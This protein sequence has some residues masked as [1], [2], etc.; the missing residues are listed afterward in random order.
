MTTTNRKAFENLTKKLAVSEEINFE[1]AESEVSSVALDKTTETLTIILKHK[2]LIPARILGD[3]QAL[4]LDE[5]KEYRAVEIVNHFPENLKEATLNEFW[6]LIIANLKESSGSFNLLDTAKWS[7]DANQLKLELASEAIKVH[8]IDK[9]V[10]Q[11]L[12]KS[13]FLWFENP[14][15]VIL[16]VI[17]EQEL[18]SYG[19]LLKAELALDIKEMLAADTTATKPIKTEKKEP[20]KL[21]YGKKITGDSQA[22]NLLHTEED[23]VLVTGKVF[24]LEHKELK[25]N[26]SIITIGLTDN[27]DSIEAKLY[28]R[29]AA[30]NK[31]L[32]EQIAEDDWLSVKGNLRI[33]KYTSQLVL[34]VSAIQ[35]YETDI[36]TDTAKT[37]RVELHLHTN[38][39]T[40]DGVSSVK[41]YIERAK[42]L[43]H[44]AIAV[45]DHGVVQAYPDAYRYGQEYGIKVIYG[46]EANVL[47][48]NSLIVTN[49]KEQ[50][51]ADETFVIF[52]IETTGLS[53]NSNK[54][55]EIGAVKINGEN[56][57]DRYSTFVNPEEEI[58][59]F[60]SDLT[61]IQN[62]DLVDAPGIKSVLAEFNNFIGDST[63]VA[64]NSRFDIAFIN[65]ALGKNG[66]RPLNN[67]IIDALALAR[68]LYPNLKN[69][70]LETLC[71]HHNIENPD[72]HR[73]LS[74]AEATANLFI[75]QLKQLAEKAIYTLKDLDLSIEQFDFKKIWPYHVSILVKNKIGLKNLYQ[76]VSDSH[77]QFFF[78]QPR[79][80]KDEISKCR[81]GL[82]IGSGC[83]KGELVDA[84]L[85]K[86]EA[87]IEQIAAYYDYLEVQPP[88]CY[89]HLLSNNLVKDQAEVIELIKKIIELGEKLSIPVVATGNVH[90]LEPEE[91]LNR[92]ILIHNQLSGARYH[93]ANELYQAHY[94]STTDML[95]EFSFVDEATAEKIVINNTRLINDQIDDLEPFPSKLYTPVIA[96]A[97]QEITELSYTNAKKIYGEELP[98]LVEARLT[99]E[100]ASIIDNGFAVIYLISHKLVAQSLADGYLVGSRGSVGSS[101]VATMT[102]IT[103]VNPLP[104]HYVCQD[105]NYSHFITDGT[106]ESGYD[107]PDK[108]CPKC[109]K[110]MKKDG[111]DIPFETFMG[112]KGDKVPDI[113]L[114]F[115]GEYQA[116]IH[117]QTEEIFGEKKVFRA[118]TIST[119]A[120]KTAFGYVR[121]YMKDNN[122]NLREAEV[123]RLAKGC[124][125][126]KRTTG[127]HPGGQIVIPQNTDVTEFTPIQRPAD[128][129]N[130]EVITTHFDYHALSGT[131]LK[132]D[133]LGHDDPTAL[134]MLQDLT[135]VDPRSIAFDDPKLYQLFTST[136]PL[137][138]E[139][140]RGEFANGAIGIPE[141]G[142]KFVRQMLDETCP[143]TFIELVRI[144]GLSHGIDVWRNNAQDLIKRGE[145]N[146]T[147]VIC[148]RDDIMLYL[149]MQGLDSSEAF[150]ISERVR[151][152][153]GLTQENINEMRKHTVPAWYIESCQKIKYMFPKAHAVAYVQMAIRIAY[154]KIYYPIEYYATYL[155]LRGGD[156]DITEVLGNHNLKDR[157]RELNRLGNDAS[158]KEKDLLNA[159]E[160]I[161][162]MNSRGI[163]FAPVELYEST[164]KQ[165]VIAPDRKS[166]IPPFSSIPGVGENL[167]NNIVEA[168]KQ[169]EFI[170]IEDLQTRCR[171]SNTI[172]EEFNRLGVL[173]GLNQTDQISLF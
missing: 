62:E 129:V 76:L 146:L 147:Q 84:L 126:V 85:N 22:I 64:Y 155:T 68:Y 3:F 152:G 78:R 167:A 15:K 159:L 54:I 119:I 9:D 75:L 1:Y 11:Y 113:D 138:I 24:S 130:S 73:A 104:P 32:V 34:M 19:K 143:T 139:G 12:N 79:I 55:I 52:D 170:S 161:V 154:Y 97:D 171:I 80:I 60:I 128:D 81:E 165:Y 122:L 108:I 166:I 169:G 135:G 27:Q 151:K 31:Q 7:I 83:A 25:N 58:S 157:V 36:V 87:E 101:F 29:N 50:T 20:K 173:K 48:S 86:T 5:L 134:K 107:L 92:R 59:Q 10:I 67:A 71:K 2:Q 61:N 46:L 118:G 39:S 44:E 93:H 18:K 17:D 37:K 23:N 38:M 111:H 51:L 82:L 41:R 145:A 153:R 114:N 45:T 8:L 96:G 42:E 88:G 142:T 164:A 28:N 141:F 105:C 99:K 116:R 63:L 70:R 13:L 95:K 43:G 110:L 33:D 172:I 40:M 47:V 69:H 133:L 117:R 149:I 125:G 168:R 91:A 100:L 123:N 121:K 115:S 53:A 132:L 14:P 148:T 98:E 160:V 136:S 162:E 16:D 35:R 66:F 90:H 156:F 74:D 140:G 94:L 109:G 131:L 144:S 4:L 26:A 106:V 30:A 124:S 56:I 158:K 77:L 127:Q 150:A 49:A 6:P 102:E 89:Q 21:L 112:Y 163:S 103:E 137:G 120:D 72:K 65:A 57:V